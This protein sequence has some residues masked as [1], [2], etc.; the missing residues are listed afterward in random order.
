MRTLEHALKDADAR[1]SRV[2]ALQ[3]SA[4]DSE[5]RLREAQAKA[6]VATRKQAAL[7]VEKETLGKHIAQLQKQLADQKRRAADSAQKA[8][9]VAKSCVED[10][11]A[12]HAAALANLHAA[13]DQAAVVAVSNAQ[14]REAGKW[15]ARIT[16]LEAEIVQL[17]A[18]L[19][20]ARAA[21]VRAKAHAEEVDVLCTA[22]NERATAATEHSK[23]MAALW[24]AERFR[25]EKQAAS[26]ADAARADAEAR[27]RKSHD[28]EAQGLQNKLRLAETREAAIRKDYERETATSSLLREQLAAANNTLELKR[29]AYAKTS[30][31]AD[32][33]QQFLSE[34]LRATRQL[35]HDVKLASEREA[36][37]LKAQI[38]ELKA[39]VES[40]AEIERRLNAT[41]KQVDANNQ[42]CVR[43]RKE[44]DAALTAAEDAQTKQSDQAGAAADELHSLRAKCKALRKELKEAELRM[45]REAKDAEK[46]YQTGTE[47]V[48]AKHGSALANLKTKLSVC[49]GDLKRAKEEAEAARKRHEQELAD[50]LSVFESDRDAK[51]D[52][53]V[54]R[55]KKQ[56]AHHKRTIATQ[57]DRLKRLRQEL[58]TQQKGAEADSAAADK[59]R[60][61]LEATVKRLKAACAK[62]KQDGDSS[63]ASSQSAGQKIVLAQEK[64]AALNDM[65]G[66]LAAAVA[67][68]AK[69][70]GYLSN[71]TVLI[72]TGEAAQFQK[73]VTQLKKELH[74]AKKV[75]SVLMYNVKYGEKALAKYDKRAAAKQG[76]A[77]QDSLTRLEQDMEEARQKEKRFQETSDNNVEELQDLK[78]G[79]KKKLINARTERKN[80]CGNMERQCQQVMEVLEAEE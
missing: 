74:N 77:R 41:L 38:H 73:K 17:K 27:A 34:Q 65:C 1:A 15:A 28:N 39:Q 55:F 16:A 40:C 22:A 70:S 67:A 64:V 31:D 53:E 42:R 10:L 11:E 21:L 58:E 76:K 68:E 69:G 36:K 9:L 50:G 47:R 24:Q 80:L 44:R 13:K 52:Q 14:E 51:L 25:L 35:L 3:R 72:K 66:K 46:A 56:E 29:L 78:K 5:R 2:T 48:I 49:R 26:D 20:E 33:K 12:A 8:A 6:S 71:L 57:I 4:E 62:L 63:G 54:A 30:Q 60:R 23:N 45:Q 75:H 7:A 61:Q 79:A 59:A 19:E 37:H 32:K 43:L 18:A